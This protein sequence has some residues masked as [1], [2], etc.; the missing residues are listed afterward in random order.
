MVSPSEPCLAVLGTPTAP[1]EMQRVWLGRQVATE[2]CGKKGRQAASSGGGSQGV[3]SSP[4]L[5]F[6]YIANLTLGVNKIG[7]EHWVGGILEF[8]RLWNE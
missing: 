4:M 6:S 7:V 1:S 3:R 2:H 8:A 5:R